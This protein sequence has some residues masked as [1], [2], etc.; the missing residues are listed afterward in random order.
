MSTFDGLHC[1]LSRIA[2]EYKELSSKVDEFIAY[3]ERLQ[4]ENSRL[5]LGKFTDEE[6]S[7]MVNAHEVMAKLSGMKDGEYSVC[8]YGVGRYRFSCCTVFIRNKK[9]A[10]CFAD[11]YS[12]KWRG[13]IFGKGRLRHA[14][15]HRNEIEA[16]CIDNV[17]MSWRPA[18]NDG[19][20]KCKECRVRDSIDDQWQR[21]QFSLVEHISGSIRPWVAL[22][23][24]EFSEKVGQWKFC[25]VFD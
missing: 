14:C 25:E 18:K 19:S 4:S 13:C 9:E 12:G 3:C 24:L 8:E 10:M 1:E 7:G 17:K 20:D 21:G 15:N 5:K 23:T 2:R 11:E 16:W 6:I 22:E